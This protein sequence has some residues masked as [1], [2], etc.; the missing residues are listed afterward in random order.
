MMNTFHCRWWLSAV[1]LLVAASS[2]AER[3]PV[4]LSLKRISDLRSN[5]NVQFTAVPPDKLTLG[6]YQDNFPNP[7]TSYSEFTLTNL[8]PD[9]IDRVLN[10]KLGD[11]PSYAWTITADNAV[12]FGLDWIAFQ[13]QL[14]E[15]K[16]HDAETTFRF[17]S[18]APLSEYNPVVAGFDSMG[19]FLARVGVPRPSESWVEDFQMQ[20]IRISVDY[21][22][23]HD[24]LE[25]LRAVQI[26]ADISGDARLRVIPEPAALP[27]LLIG[28]TLVGLVARRRVRGRPRPGL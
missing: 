23:W 15:L 22:F 10:Y 24:V 20:E 8:A 3:I 6:A 17:F 27:A 12:T 28:L 25:G 9:A 26:R 2:H 11:P 19:N 18:S 5:T 1:F 7:P 14:N 4:T 13:N 16:P 21:Y